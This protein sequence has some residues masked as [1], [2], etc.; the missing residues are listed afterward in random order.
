MY[1]VA[2][3]ESFFDHL[4][5]TRVRCKQ[6][7]H[8]RLIDPGQALHIFGQAFQFLHEFF[9]VNVAA[10]LLHQRNRDAVGAA[11]NARIFRVHLHVRMRKRHHFV[12]ARIDPQLARGD[13]KQHRGGSEHDQ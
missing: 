6:R 12:E 13:R 5:E 11:K 4:N 1:D 2:A 10:L 7:F 9:V 3:G 8:G